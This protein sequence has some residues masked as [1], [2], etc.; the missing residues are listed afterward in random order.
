VACV[1]DSNPLR[2]FVEK[3]WI[4]ILVVLLLS[5]LGVVGDCCLKLA[6]TKGL[7]PLKSKWFVLGLLIFA[8]SAF[9]W[10]Y[11]MKTIKLSTIGFFYS[12]GTVFFLVLSGVAFFGESLRPS[13]IIGFGLA[14][15]S[16]FLLARVS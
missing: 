6:A 13:E 2:G 7:H 16:F 14:I 1:T 4:A 12:L 9:G 8:G 15:A 5:L 11:A 10:V 3:K